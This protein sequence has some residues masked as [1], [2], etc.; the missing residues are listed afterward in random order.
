MGKKIFVAL[1]SVIDTTPGELL[2]TNGVRQIFHV[3]AA[4]GNFGDQISDPEARTKTTPET[5]KKCADAILRR[6]ESSRYTSY[7]ITH[8]FR[9]VLIPMLGTGQ[10]GL[11][12]D[13]V[14]PVLVASAVQFLKDNPKSR[15]KEIYFMAYSIGDVLSLHEA[16]RAMGAAG[17]L[18]PEQQG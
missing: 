3:A 16:M 10:S 18:G 9:S 17:S 2:Q 4:E 13:E 12:A 5:I 7:G 11:L 15:L 1:A 6:V 8:G 14:A